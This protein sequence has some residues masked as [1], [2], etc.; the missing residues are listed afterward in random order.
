MASTWRLSATTS[1][2][3]CGQGD[4]ISSSCG[5]CGGRLLRAGFC[6][7]GFSMYESIAFLVQLLCILCDVIPVT[8]LIS[9]LFPVNC[10]FLNLYALP[11]KILLSLL[12]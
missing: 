3:R 5:E 11:F 8:F 10:P 2:H 1:H 7:V 6:V 9:L 4:G 12:P